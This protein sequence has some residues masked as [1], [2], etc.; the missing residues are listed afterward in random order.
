MNHI[1]MT[2]EMMYPPSLIYLSLFL[3]VC[4]AVCQLVFNV[5][6]FTFHRHKSDKLHEELTVRIEQEAA[7]F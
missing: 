3:E 6:I 7:L 1:V 2:S 4:E 5:D